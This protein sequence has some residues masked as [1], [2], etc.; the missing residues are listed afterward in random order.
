M[1]G[2]ETC[3]QTKDTVLSWSADVNRMLVSQKGHKFVISLGILTTR[4]VLAF[5]SWLGIV[6]HPDLLMNPVIL[7]S[8]I[9][10]TSIM[11]GFE[12]IACNRAFQSTDM[13]PPP[14]LQA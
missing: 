5:C 4:F 6:H 13:Q 7:I 2:Q 9:I 12:G 10:L 3:T 11:E 14:H 1:E 8:S